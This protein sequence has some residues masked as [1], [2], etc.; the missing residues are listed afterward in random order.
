MSFSLEQQRAIAL[1]TARA[2]AA[3]KKKSQPEEEKTLAGFGENVIDSGKQFGGEIW[4]MVTNPVDTAKGI[5]AFAAGGAQ[6]LIPDDWGIDEG[7]K[8]AVGNHEGVIDAAG[9][10]YKDRYGGLDNLAD[11]AYEDPVGLLS[12]LSMLVG[13]GLKLGSSAAKLGGAGK[14]AK[15]LGTAGRIAD[16]GDLLN[17]G[18][19]AATKGAS[20]LRG[21][22][23]YAVG[24]TLENAKFSTTLPEAQRARMAETLLENGLDPTNPKSVQKMESLL[25]KAEAASK[26]A[27]DQFDASGGVIDAMP[28]VDNMRGVLADE[29]RLLTPEQPKRVKTVENLIGN[30]EDVLAPTQGQ[31]TGRQALDARRS[32]DAMV[33]WKAKGGKQTAKNQALKAYANGLREQLAGSV[34]GL[35][36]VNADYSKLVEAADPLRRS[37][38]RNANNSGSLTTAV[39]GGIGAGASVATGNMLPLA[40]SIIGNKALKPAT[41]QRLAQFV[42]DRSSKG[43]RSISDRALGVEIMRVIQEIEQS[44]GQNDEQ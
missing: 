5:G 3:A 23:K 16:Y 36:G 28:A 1:A 17:V 15:A 35:D 33:D 6:K 37:T 8:R 10:F 9:Q 20:K 32:A 39:L 14:T 43:S 11:T 41:R 13:G 7:L 25:D 2:K 42:F 24:N 29:G 44:T 40:A 34:K 12:D 30:A 4:D 38:A 22:A 31:M 18:V 19:G 26:Q 21:G 27:I